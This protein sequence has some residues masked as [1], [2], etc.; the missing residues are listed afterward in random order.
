MNKFI[1]SA[2][3]CL[4]RWNR[5]SVPKHPHI[6]FRRRGTTQKKT[7]NI[8]NMTVW[9]QEFPKLFCVRCLNC[10]SRIAYLMC[11]K[12][13]GLIPGRVKRFYFLVNVRIGSGP[14]QLPFHW[15][16]EVLSLGDRVARACSWPLTSVLVPRLRITGAVPF[17]P[18]FNC[19]VGTGTALAFWFYCISASLN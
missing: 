19:M 2:P 9:N 8:Q 7:Y 3:T 11:C 13:W 5:Q 15:V 4:W 12:I 1:Y 6:K 17:L 18:L 14:V 16:P 10:S